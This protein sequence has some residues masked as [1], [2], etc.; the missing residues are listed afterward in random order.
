M[1]ENCTKIAPKLQKYCRHKIA[2]K[3]DTKYQSNQIYFYSQPATLPK[4]AL[5]KFYLSMA[6]G[7]SFMISSV[8]PTR[9]SDFY[10]YLITKLETLALNELSSMLLNVSHLVARYSVPFI[11]M[12]YKS[13]HVEYTLGVT[14][15]RECLRV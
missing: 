15:Q 2:V 8:V 13:F 1:H 3:S 9:S 4:D 5:A 7:L 12:F 14:S 10:A 6:F 11:C